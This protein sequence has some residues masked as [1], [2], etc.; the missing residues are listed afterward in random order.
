M[1]R[2]VSYASG[3]EWVLFAHVN[4]SSD[5]DDAYEEWEDFK[6][7]LATAFKAAFPSLYDISEWIGREDHAILRNGHG[8]LGVS[9]YYDLVSVWFVPA[10]NDLASQWASRI[11]GRAASVIESIATRLVRTGT[12]SNGESFYRRIEK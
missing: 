1:S 4:L 7:S 2:S 3:A 10:D 8:W 12:A 6:V 9:Q 11:E 5:E